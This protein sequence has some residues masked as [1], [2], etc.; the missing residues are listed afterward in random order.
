MASR[1]LK[2]K[3]RALTYRNSPQDPSRVPIR[4]NLIMRGSPRFLS[5]SHDVAQ[6]GA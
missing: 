5:L 1:A 2:A 4:L 3:I 6:A